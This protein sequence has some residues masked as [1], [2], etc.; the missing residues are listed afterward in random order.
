[1]AAARGQQAAKQTRRRHS[2]NSLD[3]DAAS[4][5]FFQFNGHQRGRVIRRVH[6][7]EFHP[8][9]VIH[10]LTATIKWNRPNV[11]TMTSQESL[12]VDIE[13]RRRGAECGIGRV[14]RDC[15]G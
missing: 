6:S 14:E 7:F 1:M 3:E 10:G 5:L 9:A 2:W 8:V 15:G 4:F 11:Q 13:W 12:H